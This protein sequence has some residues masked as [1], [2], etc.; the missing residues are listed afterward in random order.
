MARDRRIYGLFKSFSRFSLCKISFAVE[1]VL[2]KGSL[3][4]AFC[5]ARIN[6]FVIEGGIYKIGRKC[7]SCR[8][9]ETFVRD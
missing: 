5:K 3:D 2:N 7:A 4:M 1:L 6:S 9:S 8:L